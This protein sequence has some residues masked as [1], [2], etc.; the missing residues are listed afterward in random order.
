MEELIAK[1]IRETLKEYEKAKNNQNLFKMQ[2]MDR[3]KKALGNMRD[4]LVNSAS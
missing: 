3:L 4:S 1:W 2:E